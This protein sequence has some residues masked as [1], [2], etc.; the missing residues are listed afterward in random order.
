MVPTFHIFTVH[1]VTLEIPDETDRWSFEFSLPALWHFSGRRAIIYH[2]RLSYFMNNSW[3]SD[4]VHF[5]KHLILLR[6]KQ[7]FK[8]IVRNLKSIF[9]SASM[10]H[11]YNIYFLRIHGDHVVVCIKVF[12]V[13]FYL[14]ITADVMK[15][16][17]SCWLVLIWYGNF[18]RRH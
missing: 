1:E 3:R 6:M 14:L 8:G 10:Y 9:D 13:R 12:I 11:F 7:V 17:K 15:K 18:Y 2:R 16:R 5:E 4:S